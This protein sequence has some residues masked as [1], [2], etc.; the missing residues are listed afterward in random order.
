[1]PSQL[2]VG[3]SVPTYGSHSYCP[4]TDYNAFAN[5]LRDIDRRDDVLV[6]VWQGECLYQ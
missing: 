3:T 4:H 1:M 5:A 2:K 6:T